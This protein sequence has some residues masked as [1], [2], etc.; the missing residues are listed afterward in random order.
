MALVN[1]TDLLASIGNW[2]NRRDL[3][4]QIPD[5]ITM[6]EAKLRRRLKVRDEVARVQ[7]TI[8]TEFTEL[9]D[10][11]RSLKSIKLIVNGMDQPF[12][13]CSEAGIISRR[14]E[15]GSLVGQP[16]YYAIVG[17]ALEVKPAPDTS[18]VLEMSYY[19][20][21]PALAANATN[22][23]LTKHPDLYLYS[24]L[25]QSAPFLKDDDR[26]QVWQSL[27]EG[28]FAEIEIDDQRSE[29]GGNLRMRAR[30]IG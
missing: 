2:L 27:A 3:T 29:Y 26:V 8:S 23:L 24:S 19:A 10:D 22:W 17:N 28:I 30:S 1:Y 21:I 15:W 5:F 9:P 16:R 11:F 14:A 25:L 20:N 12:E 7:T 18:Y 4:D 13:Q 6:A